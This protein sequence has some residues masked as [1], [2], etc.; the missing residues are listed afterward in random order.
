MRRALLLV[1]LL[2]LTACSSERAATGWHRVPVPAAPSATPTADAMTWTLP[3]GWQAVRERLTS[4]SEPVHR[5]AAATFALRQDKPDR[6]CR[7]DTASRQLP[8]DGALVYILESLETAA[9][10]RGLAKLPSRPRHFRIPRARSYECLGMGAVIHWTEQGRALEANVLLGPKA[11]RAR[12]RQVEALLD[13]LVVQRVPPPPA[14]IGWRVIRSGSYDSIRVPPGWSARALQ[15]PHRTHRPRLLFRVANPA[16]TVVVKI[17]ELRRGTTKPAE[18][19]RFR[20][21]RFSVAVLARAG[22]SPHDIDQA[23]ISARSVGVSGVGR[24]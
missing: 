15:H 7:P 12:R 14:P 10:P 18:G 5:L 17:T 22:A 11:T 1:A 3:A 9:H 23:R 21:F 20:G 6:D 16:N 2:A 13:S 24:G 4:L 8:A 19:F